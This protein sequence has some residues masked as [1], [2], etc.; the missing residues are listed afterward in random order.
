MAPILNSAVGVNLKP[1]NGPLQK[2][3]EDLSEC[4]DEE[5]LMKLLAQE[6]IFFEEQV[7][8][9]DCVWVKQE[10]CD[11]LSDLLCCI[12]VKSLDHMKNFGCSINLSRLNGML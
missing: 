9:H 2:L 5:T 1:I 4:T 11:L 10:T 7:R 8:L 3:L 12:V 6:E